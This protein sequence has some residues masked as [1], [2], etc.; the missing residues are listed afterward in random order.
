MKASL[1]MT[2]SS[3][4]ALI[5]LALFVPTTYQEIKIFFLLLALFGVALLVG[6]SKLV[7]SGETLGCTVCWAG[8]V[9]F[10][11]S[12]YIADGDLDFAI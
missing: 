1:S 3:L 12:A 8:S 2:G 6:Y 5:F 7:W 10:D 9:C 4:L 11:W